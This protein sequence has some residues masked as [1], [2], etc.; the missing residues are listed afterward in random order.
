MADQFV[1]HDFNA[2]TFPFRQPVPFEASANS[3]VPWGQALVNE[4]WDSQAIT[5]GNTG[6]IGIDIK[7]PSDY[8]SILRR[9]QLQSVS[10]S[11]IAW[12]PGEIGF[13]YQNPG[14][15]Y[16]TTVA[17]FDEQTYNWYRLVRGLQQSSRD[18]FA[19]AVNFRQWDIGQ[20][21][22]NSGSTPIQSY[23]ECSTPSELPLWI[24][25][26][27]DANLQ[28]RSVVIQ[29]INNTAS[30][31]ANK[32]SL[33]MAFDLYTLEQAYAAGVMSSPRVF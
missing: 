8:V 15:P 2:Q 17:A 21:S 12:L 24:P 5:A 11:T 3:A 28:Q 13:A 9:F 20:T 14:G 16:K 27:A 25:P 6:T 4:S 26:Q 33:N 29:L 19:S 30:S 18:R 7:L 23:Q 22:D 10:A 1:G 32:F 31:A